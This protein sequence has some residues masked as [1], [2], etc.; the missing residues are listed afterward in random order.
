MRVL[1][2]VYPPVSPMVGLQRE[3]SSDTVVGGF[4]LRGGDKVW[5]NVMGIHHDP[6]YW[7]DPE[8]PLVLYL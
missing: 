1:C 7:R 6:K 2:R 3:A 5:I 4:Q 8:V